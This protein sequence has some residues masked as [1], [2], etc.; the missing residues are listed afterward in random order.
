MIYIEFMTHKV[1]LFS[2]IQEKLTFLQNNLEN[3]DILEVCCIMIVNFFFNKYYRL[4]M[5]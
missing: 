4:K 5:L 3:F 1:L 2:F